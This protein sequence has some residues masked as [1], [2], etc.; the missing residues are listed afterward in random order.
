MSFRPGESGNPE[1]RKKGNKNTVVD[2]MR[3][4]RRMTGSALKTLQ[5]IMLDP[6]APANSRVRASE[7]I[8]DRGWGAVAK[9]ITELLRDAKPEELE[10]LVAQVIEARRK[11]GG[12]GGSPPMH[13]VQ[14]DDS[15]S[16]PP[17]NPQLQ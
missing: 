1:G 10:R 7:C 14:Q 4:A 6:T 15:A 3:A 13:I 12:G 9:D 11:K 8:L 2:V 17:Q 16:T 5:G